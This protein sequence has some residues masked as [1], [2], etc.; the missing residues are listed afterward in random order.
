MDKRKILSMLLQAQKDNERSVTGIIGKTDD[1]DETTIYSNAEKTEVWVRINGMAEPYS[2]LISDPAAIVPLARV[3]LKYDVE[4][5]RWVVAGVN[6]SANNHYFQNV[7]GFTFAIQPHNH[8]S[9]DTG[10]DLGPDTVGTAQIR[11]DAVTQT[12]L[13]DDSVGT[14]QIQAAAVGNSEL[15]NDAVKVANLNNLSTSTNGYVRQISSDVLLTEKYNSTNTAP[16]T[17]NDGTQGYTLFSKWFDILNLRKYIAFDVNTAAAIWKRYLFSGDVVPTD[18]TTLTGSSAAIV[19]QTASD[20]FS[21]INYN[22]GDNTGLVYTGSSIREKMYAEDY[23]TGSFTTSGTTASVIDSSPNMASYV[24]STFALRMTTMLATSCSV[25]GTTFRFM[26]QYR[27]DNAG[28]P[29]NSNYNYI[30]L[31]YDHT[32]ALAM[33]VNITTVFLASRMASPAWGDA[34]GVYDVRLIVYRVGGTGDLTVNSAAK[35]SVLKQTT[36]EEVHA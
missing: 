4:A 2:A 32:T 10:D 20:T 24:T 27:Y 35:G 16:T 11:A 12:E 33:P 13:A 29:A 21:S 5:S 17:S 7:G 22:F 18:T 14:A 1:A 3:Y 23:N 9:P 26:W 6:A 19:T 34:G 15:A 36:Y 30:D 31:Y 25:A 8:T 28:T